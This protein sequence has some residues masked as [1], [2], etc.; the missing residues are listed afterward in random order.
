MNL[1][2][3]SICDLSKHFIKKNEEKENDEPNIVIFDYGIE[4]FN[5]FLKAI[6]ITKLNLLTKENISNFFNTFNFKEFLIKIMDYTTQNQIEMINNKYI[7][8]ITKANNY[9]IKEPVTSL[10]TDKHGNNKNKAYNINENLTINDLYVQYGILNYYLEFFHKNKDLK[11]T[12]KSVVIKLNTFKL[13]INRENKKIQIFFNFSSIKE[14]TLFHY[15]KT[16][17]N[18]LKLEQKYEEVITYLKEFKFYDS[19]IRLYQTSFRSHQVNFFFTL[20]T[21]K[22]ADFME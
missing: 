13:I 9:Y 3:E 18:L 15:L 10:I 12:P 21:K 17:S 4:D 7:D 14:K 16:S 11:K 22:V 5:L 20:I 2:I 1:T 8:L 19:S 6:N